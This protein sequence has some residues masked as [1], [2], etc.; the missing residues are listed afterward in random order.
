MRPRPSHIAIGPVNIAMVA[1]SRAIVTPLAE[2]R[3]PISSVGVL[4]LKRAR[5]EKELSPASLR[6]SASSATARANSIWDDYAP[7]NCRI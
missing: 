7:A 6:A 4:D 2:S 3:I 1:V 5:I